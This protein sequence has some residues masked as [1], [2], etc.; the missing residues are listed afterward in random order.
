[1]QQQHAQTGGRRPNPF[2]LMTA[3][4]AS[5]AGLDDS[6]AAA[7]PEHSGQPVQLQQSQ[8]SRRSRP[9]RRGGRQSSTAGGSALDDDAGSDA[10]AYMGDCPV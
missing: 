5:A 7:E 9:S 8:R 2:A 6:P 10:S 3:A 1:V 4:A